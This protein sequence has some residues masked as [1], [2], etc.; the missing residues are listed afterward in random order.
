M[1]ANT[2]TFDVDDDWMSTHLSLPGLVTLYAPEH[3]APAAV[4][5]TDELLMGR[6]PPADLLL[7]FRSVSHAHARSLR[8]GERWL[9]ED[10]QSHNGTFVNGARVLR[11]VLSHGDQLRLGAVVLELREQGIE[12]FFEPLA[13]TPL[14]VC[15]EALVGPSLSALRREILRFAPVD[16]PVLVL[17][18]SGTGK[19]LV[20]RALHAASGRAGG[21][22]AVN[23]AAMPASLMEAELFGAKRGA[24]TGLDHDRLGLVRSADGG[25]LFLDEIGDMPLEAQAKL[26]R[27]L[28]TRL[29]TPLGSHLQIPVDLRIV[30]ATHR[31]LLDLVAQQRFRTDLYARLAAHTIELSPLRE[32]KEDIVPL[33]EHFLRGDAPRPTVAPRFMIGLLRYD[34]PLNVRELHAAIRRAVVLADQGALDER[35]LPPAVHALTRIKRED[36]P[37]SRPRTHAPSQ[38]E[39]RTLLHKHAGNVAAVARE[40]GKDRAQIHRWLKLHATS[41]ST[42]RR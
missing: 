1:N 24:F 40:L 38:A 33:V 34:W 29:V 41:A 32:R 11:A 14:P 18:E 36:A 22:A 28:D 2:D 13:S 17:G 42:F 30:S 16:L 27:V 15:V 12:R 21:F 39:L 26:L 3:G 19:E 7:P 9:V 35:H 37:A 8:R 25:T 31:P 5:L 10:L 23:C 20:A 6:A 4:P